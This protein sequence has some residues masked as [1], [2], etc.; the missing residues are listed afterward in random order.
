MNKQDQQKPTTSHSSEYRDKVFQFLENGKVNSTYTI[1]RICATEN[2]PAFIE[3]VKEYM[4]LTP[5]AGG[6]EFNADYTKLM[7]LNL[8]FSPKQINRNIYDK[9]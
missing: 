1:N 8:D 3:I 4:D 6:W 2:Q 7:R 9:K 5:F